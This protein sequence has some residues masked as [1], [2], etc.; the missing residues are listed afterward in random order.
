LKMFEENRDVSE[1][2]TALDMTS[3]ISIT[4]D[5]GHITYVNDK[6]C[7]LSQCSKTELLGRKHNEVNLG[8]YTE[9]CTREISMQFAKGEPWKGEVKRRSKY[10][11]EY[12][13]YTVMTP[14]FNEEGSLQQI[15]TIGVQI[16][17]GD[18][19]EKMPLGVVRDLRDINAA[20][21]AAS[22]VAITDSKGVI[23]YV[24]NKF[25]EISKY[26]REELLGKTHRL[27]NS[28]NHPSTFFKE[29]WSTITQG[30]VWNGEVNNRA[31]DGSEYWMN[32]TVVPFLDENGKPYRYVSIRYE[33]TDR[34]KAERKLAEAMQNDF[35]RTVQHMQNCVFRCVV[36]EDRKITYTLCEGKIAEELGMTSERIKGKTTSEI[37]P[38]NIA[39]QLDSYIRIGLTGKVAHGELEYANQLYHVSISPIDEGGL[40]T[41]VVGSIISI[42]EQ[43]QAEETIYHLAHYDM[44]TKLPNRTLFSKKLQQA[45]MMAKVNN[46]SISLMFIDLDRF[47]T[48]NDTLGHTI[49]D[50]LLKVIAER[51]SNSFRGEGL[52]SRQGGDEFTMFIPNLSRE[53]AGERA[54]EIMAVVSEPCIFN[55][56]ELYVT[57][58]IGISFYPSD[59]DDEEQLQQHAEAAMYL[60]KESGKNNYKIYTEDLHKAITR[61]LKLE[62]ELR[63]ALEKN[64]FTLHYQPKMNLETNEV[65]GMEALIRWEHPELGLIPPMQFIPIAEETGL[66]VPI[67]EWVMHTAC[68]Q[69]KAWQEAGHSEMTIAVNISVR[70]LMQ[71]DLLEMIERILTDTGLQP[72]YLELEITESM[73]QDA[74]NTIRMLKR[75]QGLGVSIS[76]DDFG[77]GYSSLSYLSQFPINRLKIDQS[78]VRNLNASN[79][80]IIKTIIDIAHNMNISVIAEGIETQQH[81]DFLKEQ[82]C[83]EGQGY[84]YSRPLQM[85]DA[86]HYIKRRKTS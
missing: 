76:I 37:L 25:C 14:F 41:E 48:I 43:K 70:Q 57:P 79:Q 75:I 85:K 49:G 35:R 20:F 32:T 71:N 5:K 81:V 17:R 2:F 8:Y 7:E 15:V 59:G 61:K 55:H 21:N 45:I 30:K 50:S 68:R 47:K 31:K 1:I 78:F 11:N 38:F 40:I 60:A 9:I 22:I 44:L 80:A 29:M 63:K 54:R 62:S 6:Y 19:A 74:N 26:S 67:G 52:L 51:L 10:G 28:G 4:D 58:S 34:I 12:W 18:T 65:I 36:D 33:I 86:D 82:M 42:T 84:F 53:D 72:E 77:T 39:E 73:A 69:T 83:L 3:I 56:M 16:S 64:Q 27:I 66:I 24:N 23:S 46:E 13:V